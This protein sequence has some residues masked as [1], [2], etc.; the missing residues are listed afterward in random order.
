MIRSHLLFPS[1]GNIMLRSHLLSVPLYQFKNLSLNRSITTSR[2][3]L[4]ESP[5]E[6]KNDLLEVY[7]KWN[8]FEQEVK[9]KGITD[10]AIKKGTISEFRCFHKCDKCGKSMAWFE[11]KYYDQIFDS[12]TIHDALEHNVLNSMLHLFLEAHPIPELIPK[13]VP[14]PEL[15]Q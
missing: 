7:R 13:M 1:I 9:K 15:N 10:Y 12:G 14:N 8:N 3:L 4:R 11:Y 6:T 5:T 2:H